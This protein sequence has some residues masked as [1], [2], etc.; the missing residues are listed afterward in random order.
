MIMTIQSKFNLVSKHSHIE[1]TESA[2]D[3]KLYDIRII[4]R[5]QAK[6][7]GMVSGK[8]TTL[9]LIGVVHWY[10]DAIIWI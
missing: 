8:V 4:L 5:G 9:I 1:S 10:V 3:W 7:M 2:A 6:K